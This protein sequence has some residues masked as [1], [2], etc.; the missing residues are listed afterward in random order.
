MEDCAGDPENE[1]RRLEE[2]GGGFMGSDTEVG[3]PGVEGV[4]DGAMGS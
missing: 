4:G 1:D 2:N 3:V